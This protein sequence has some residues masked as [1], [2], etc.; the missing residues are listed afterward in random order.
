MRRL[1]LAAMSA[2]LVTLAAC[3]QKESADSYGES[4][5]I[6][7]SNSTRMA[8]VISS[9]PTAADYA[10]RLES[11]QSVLITVGA[12][13]VQ[14]LKGEFNRDLNSVL[15]SSGSLKPTGSKYELL[16]QLRASVWQWDW[17]TVSDVDEVT[18]MM[19][20]FADIDQACSK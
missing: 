9:V 7:M 8:M 15:E 11:L 1:V 16:E 17:A 6:L 20:A 18:K 12:N 5:P 19:S 10:A 4:C 3:G 2:L 13:S 14:E